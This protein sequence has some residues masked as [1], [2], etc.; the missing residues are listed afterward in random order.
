MTVRPQ[1][2]EVGAAFHLELAQPVGGEPGSEAVWCPERVVDEGQGTRAGE[3]AELCTVLEIR[4]VV[5]NPYGRT[6]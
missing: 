3:G 6:S 5:S 1:G 4:P 2:D